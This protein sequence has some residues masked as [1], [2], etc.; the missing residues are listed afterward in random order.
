MSRLDAQVWDDDPRAVLLRN[1]AIPGH[2]LH[3]MVDEVRADAVQQ[4][5]LA[6]GA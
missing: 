1:A 4:D 3:K 5:E 6:P 2:G